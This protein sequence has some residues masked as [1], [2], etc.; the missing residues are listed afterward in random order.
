MD[1]NTLLVHSLEEL[2]GRL[3]VDDVDSTRELSG[4]HELDNDELVTAVG[5]MG[6]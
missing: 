6:V 1:E 5:Y 3:H 4:H 2:E